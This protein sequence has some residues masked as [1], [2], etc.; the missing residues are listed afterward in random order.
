[1]LTFKIKVILNTS[2]KRKYNRKKK[3][4]ANVHT[5]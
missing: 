4:Q 1:M 5:N 3:N 2:G